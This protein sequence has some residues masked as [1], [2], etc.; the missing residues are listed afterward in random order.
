[1]RRSLAAL[2]ASAPAARGIGLPLLR[3]IRSFYASH[4]ALDKTME[5]VCKEEGFGA[6][7]CTL[8]ASTGLSLAESVVRAGQRDGVD[9]SA[10]VG[11]ATAFFSY[12][13]LYTSPSPRD[14][15]LS[16]MPSSA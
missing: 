12:C 7:V 5:Q 9:T 4:N 1:M 13:L 11:D 3:A 14:G 10:L 8:T 16:R 2:S 15:L 6:S